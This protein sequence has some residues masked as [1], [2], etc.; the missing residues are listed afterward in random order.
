[1]LTVAG[2]SKFSN[3]SPVHSTL[4]TLGLASF[5]RRQFVQKA[6]SLYEIL[7]AGWLLSGLLPQAVAVVTVLTFLAFLGVKIYLAVRQPEADCG[8]FGQKHKTP[9]DAVSLTV[10]AI[11]VVLA[12]VNVWLSA[13]DSVSP[14]LRLIVFMGYSAYVAVCL[15][16]LFQQTRLIQQKSRV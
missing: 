10:S 12:L 13:H 3:P 15:I 5:S 2:L 1:M 9:V 14:V 4:R 16:N 8:C 7:L 11:W 6:L